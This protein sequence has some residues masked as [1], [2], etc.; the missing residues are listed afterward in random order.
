MVVDEMS[1]VDVLL[2][3]HLLRALRLSCKVVLV[4][5]CDQLRPW[6]QATCSGI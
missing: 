6:V 4:G 1:M 5:D 2:F 3:E